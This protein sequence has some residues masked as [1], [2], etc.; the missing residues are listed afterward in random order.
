MAKFDLS[1]L[2]V[3]LNQPVEKAYQVY[4]EY[5][6]VLIK[7]LFT[8]YIDALNNE[9]EPYIS[10]RHPGIDTLPE[11]MKD[12]AGRKTKRLTQVPLISKTFRESMIDHPYLMGCIDKIFENICDATWMNTTQIMQVEPGEKAQF[13]HR[14]SENYQIIRRMGKS[15]PE[16]TSNCIVALDDI[17][18]DMGATRVVAGSH[19]WDDFDRQATYEE[20][21][22][23]ELEKGDGFL[24]SGKVI[25]G[26]GANVSGKPRRAMAMAFNAG[27]LTPEEAFPMY[28]KWEMVKGLSQRA[29]QLL[30]FR[31]FH[32]TCLEG[33]SLWTVNFEELANY[34]EHAE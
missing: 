32:H 33:G 11:H 9:L 8:D 14:D 28:M 31:S 1:V 3:T 2:T 30:G 16:V 22:P 21:F 7:G 13:L 24:F 25:H 10:A 17:T 12:F 20:T 27:W 5:G 34:L 18:E 15:A 4:C 6:G 29:Q 23:L 26:A 19:L